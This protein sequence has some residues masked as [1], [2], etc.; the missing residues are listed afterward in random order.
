M[1]RH[2]GMS[3]DRATLTYRF[4]RHGDI[5]TVTGILEDPV[6]LAEPYIL[7]EA[8]RQDANANLFP[9]TACEPIEELPYLHENPAIVPHYLPG[10]NPFV[11]E[12]TQKHNIPLEAVL[13]GPET[14]YPEF[15]KKIKDKYVLPPPCTEGCGGPPA[16][17]A[18]A[19]P[20][21]GRGAPPPR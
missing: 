9:L 6:Y 13:G 3:S 12:V 11:N 10:K 16:P 17:P 8:F 4:V 19:A 7:T 20:A 2:R 15:R 14:M 1:K 5:L 18:A 21:A